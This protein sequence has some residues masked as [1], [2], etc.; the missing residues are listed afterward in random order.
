MELLVA[1][2]ALATDSVEGHRSWPSEV[3]RLDLL[4]VVGSR[5]ARLASPEGDSP[6]RS[7][8]RSSAVQI[9][10]WVSMRGV[11]GCLAMGRL[12]QNLRNY[13]L[14]RPAFPSWRKSRKAT[15]EVRGQRRYGRRAI[16]QTPGKAQETQQQAGTRYA[17][18]G[19]TKSVPLQPGARPSGKACTVA[20]PT[21]SATASFIFPPPRKWRRRQEST[22]LGRPDCS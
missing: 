3:M 10:P 12:C 19:S 1:A 15:L 11:F 7:A 14:N 9:W 4:K 16:R 22:S 13:S 17:C 2:S 6:E 18:A 8:S 20:A 21:I 5:P